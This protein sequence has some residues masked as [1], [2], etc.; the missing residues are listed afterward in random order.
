MDLSPTSLVAITTS[1]SAS[2][3][4]NNG[5]LPKSGVA[6][7]KTAANKLTSLNLFFIINYQILKNLKTDFLLIL[8]KKI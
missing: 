6:A 7:T 2:A 4:E 3:L 1:G 5:A 8:G